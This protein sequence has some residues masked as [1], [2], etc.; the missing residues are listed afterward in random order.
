MTSMGERNIYP[1]PF[2]QL[3]ANQDPS[4][5][6]AEYEEVEE[7]VHATCRYSSF[8]KKTGGKKWSIEQTKEFYKVGPG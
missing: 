4:S 5:A 1:C 3:V 8:S 6:E 2:H 7:G